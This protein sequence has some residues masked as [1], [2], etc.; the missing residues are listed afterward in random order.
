MSEHDIARDDPDLVAVVEELGDL[1][2][3]RFSELKVVEIPD[4][5]K[6]EVD[7]SDGMEHIA[8]VHRIWA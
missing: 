6:W 5:V 3:S 8:E 1:A 7:E 2:N 4:N